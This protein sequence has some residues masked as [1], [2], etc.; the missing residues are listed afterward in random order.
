MPYFRGFVGCGVKT[1]LLSLRFGKSL[2][3]GYS[4]LSFFLRLGGKI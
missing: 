3:C 2:F 4:G 1:A